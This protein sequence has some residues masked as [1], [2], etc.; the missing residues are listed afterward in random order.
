MSEAQSIAVGELLHVF[1]ILFLSGIEDV[2]A[3]AMLYLRRAEEIK[4]GER[5]P[6]AYIECEMQAALQQ[7]DKWRENRQRRAA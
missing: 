6:Y 7:R 1:N 4:A 5:D 2:Q 3:F